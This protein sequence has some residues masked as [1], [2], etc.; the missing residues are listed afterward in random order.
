[1]EGELV[2]VCTCCT[3]SNVANNCT[4]CGRRRGNRSLA[5]IGLP[6]HPNLT[7]EFVGNSFDF[8]DV[9]RAQGA[10][11]AGYDVN[12]K[13]SRGFDALYYAVTAGRADIAKLLLEHG[14]DPNHGD[15]EAQ[16]APLHI[17]CEIG[18]EALVELL[19]QN[20]ADFK[21][22]CVLQGFAPLHHATNQEYAGCIRLLLE[23][24]AEI[25]QPAAISGQ[26]SLMIAVLRKNINMVRLL[27]KYGA[28]IKQK[29]SDGCIALDF[30]VDEKIFSCLSFRALS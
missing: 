25:D 28:N 12:Y 9:R 26:T 29:D 20:G 15:N 2:W 3:E 23:N 16:K 10:I 7:K 18:N 22:V 21:K 19:L 13:D 14:A 17:A 8:S 5:S 30:A 1:M 24:G 6:L 11:F 27:L 4:R